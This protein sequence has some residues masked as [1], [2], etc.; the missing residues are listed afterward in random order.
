MNNNKFIVNGY[1]LQHTRP[2]DLF[3]FSV[4]TGI[5]ID[6]KDLKYLLNEEIIKHNVYFLLS[7]CFENIV[8]YTTSYLSP[9]IINGNGFMIIDRIRGAMKI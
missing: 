5:D 9:H 8:Y 4:E 1:I 6:K 7:I 3:E 2:L